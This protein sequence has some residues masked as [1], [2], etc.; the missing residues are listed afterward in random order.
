MKLFPVFF[1]TAVVCLAQPLYDLILRGG[2]VIDPKNHIDAVMD[3]AIRNGKIAA[4]ERSIDPA[5]A[6]KTVA[7]AGLYV[8]PGLV[9]IHTHLFHTTNMRAAWAGDWSVDPDVLSFRS[10]VT[11]MCD[12]GSSGWR[13]FD[14]LVFEVIERAQT[15]VLAFINIAG[16]GMIT[17]VPEQ[18][19]SDFKPEEILKWKKKYPRL[20]VGVKTAHYQ[21]PDWESV[22]RAVEAGKL[23]GIPV[24]VDFGHFLPER[25]YWQLV[26]QHLRPGDI[27]THMFRGPVPWVD[28]NGKVYDYLYKARARGVKFDIGHGNA[29]FVLRSAVPATQQGFYPDTISTDL[30]AGSMNAAMMDLPTTMSKLLAMGMPLAAVIQATTW[31][32]AQEIQH[33]ELGHLTPGATADVSVWRLMEGDFGYGDASGGRITGKQ[34]LLCEMTLMGGRVA[35]DWNQRVKDDYR[36]LG[37]TYGV[38]EGVDQIIPPP[39]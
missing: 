36:K 30:H 1:L 26:T 11:T 8:T 37:P 13:N 24:M 16:L 23:A 34:R 27:S 33:P 12:A 25:P 21:Q 14:R 9:D 10:G 5:R 4:V 15:R 38:R 32:P 6:T 19:K 31:N 3:V 29:S 17:D 22:D 2:H 18:D 20:V 28:A 35:W 7:L 39:Q